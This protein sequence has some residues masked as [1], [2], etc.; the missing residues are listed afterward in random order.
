V[1]NTCGTVG[2]V[3]QCV[4]NG[5]ACD[6]TTF[7]NA[8]DGSVLT[9]CTGGH[10]ATLDCASYGLGVTTCS[11]DKTDGAICAPVS[12]ACPGGSPET[13]DAGVITFCMFGVKTT[14]DC[15]SFGLSGC[16][17]SSTTPAAARCT[18]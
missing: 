3:A 14:V 10:V 1:A 18:P 13:C 6:A 15:K 8:C 7:V 12:T 2:G 17:V 16:K 9:T 5:S 11:V 4:G